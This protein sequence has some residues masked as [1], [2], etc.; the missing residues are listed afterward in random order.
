MFGCEKKNEPAKNLFI[1]DY[2]PLSSTVRRSGSFHNNDYMTS[3]EYYTRITCGGIPPEKLIH[4]LK[5]SA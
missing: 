1:D 3:T 5:I 2:H 4:V